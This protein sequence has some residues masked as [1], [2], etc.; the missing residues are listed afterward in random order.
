VIARTVG[1]EASV[2]VPR[3]R[4]IDPGC[5]IGEPDSVFTMLEKDAFPVRAQ[6]S[7]WGDTG[8]KPWINCAI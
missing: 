6:G 7:V 2:T 4:H 8:S 3:P 1:L 5:M